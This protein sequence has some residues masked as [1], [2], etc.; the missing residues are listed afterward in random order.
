MVLEL[1]PTCT[2]LAFNFFFKTHLSPYFKEISKTGGT[3]IR[4]GNSKKKPS[5]SLG[6]MEIIDPNKLG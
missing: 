2:C 4:I 3:Q 5:A 6:N 1:V